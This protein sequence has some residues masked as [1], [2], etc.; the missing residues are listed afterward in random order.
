ML[1]KNIIE[2]IKGYLKFGCTVLGVNKNKIKVIE[3]NKE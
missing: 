3:N 2:D 1:T